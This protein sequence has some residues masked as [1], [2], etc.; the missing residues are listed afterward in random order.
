MTNLPPLYGHHTKQAIDN[1][2][3]TGHRW[4][5]VFIWALACVKEA[6][7][8]TN[9]R[10][11]YLPP[12]VATAIIEAC[13]ALAAGELDEAIV[14]DPLGG[15]AGTATHMNVNEVLARRAQDLL[16][17]QGDATP[18]DPLLHVNRHQ[19]TNDVFPTAF[20]VAALRL[21]ADLETA[22][23]GLQARLQDQERQC[24]HVVKVGRTQLRD[25]VP[26]TLGQEFGAYAEAIGR[27]R[28]RLS[29]ARERLKQVN[30]GGTAVG[31]GLGAPREYIL[32]VTEWL[33]RITNLP[34]CRADNLIDATQNWDNLV[35]VMGMVAALA[36]NL[37]KIGNDLR[38]LYSGPHCGLGEIDLPATQM[39]STIMAGKTN[40]VVPEAVVQIALRALGACHT[41]TLCAGM[42]QLELNHLVPL[43]ALETM[44]A[45]TLLTQA[46]RLLDARCIA[47][48]TPNAQRCQELVERSSAL[49]TVLVPFHGYETVARLE[50][51]AR[52]TGQSLA[53][54][55]V[56]MGILDAATAA[57]L[58]APRRMY[59]LGFTPEDEALCQRQP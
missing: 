26:I 21:I 48:L 41:V 53:E 15:G 27:D 11:G 46:V 54:A 7:A 39:G 19:S 52:S 55:A 30:L 23:S 37:L 25:A 2:P 36:S 13:H 50:A 1:A 33:R 47:G 35:E 58:L 6:C 44:E 59:Q 8:Q 45:L 16:A 22:V 49:A 29:K 14:V 42:G 51:H 10:L 18:V 24:A 43:M 32:R 5:R 28:W 56:A 12:S 20:T 38:L 57:A 40:P 9:A 3:G 17:A 34:V 31:T 4:P